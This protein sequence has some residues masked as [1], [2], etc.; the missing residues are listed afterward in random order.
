MAFFICK[1]SLE[2]CNEVF[3]NGVEYKIKGNKSILN[4]NFGNVQVE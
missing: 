2:L 1:F 4:N 3:T